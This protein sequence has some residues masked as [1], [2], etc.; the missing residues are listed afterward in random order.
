MKKIENEKIIKAKKKAEID[1]CTVAAN[2]EMIR[3]NYEDE[4]CDE[5]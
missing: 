5:K 2:P 1:R 4:P 3:N